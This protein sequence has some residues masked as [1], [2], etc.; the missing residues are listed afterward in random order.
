MDDPLILAVVLGGSTLAIFAVYLLNRLIGG[1]D[2]AR[3]SDWSH[4]ARLLDEDLMGFRAETGFVTQDGRIALVF[5]RDG[6][7]LGI[8]VARGD[9]FVL[10]S[11]GPGDLKGLKQTSRALIILTGD[12][13]LAKI[14]L[15]LH[16]DGVA[17]F[18]LEALERR[19]QPFVASADPGGQNA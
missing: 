9:V 14:V 12:W 6:A 13:A 5:E 11:F 4:A 7:R 2:A 3:L 19:L 18:G 15:P 16:D 10:R 1:W 17:S 8:V